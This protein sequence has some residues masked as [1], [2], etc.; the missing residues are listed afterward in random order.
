[1]PKF[2]A[3]N[4]RQVALGRG[5]A[6]SLR[7]EPYRAALKAGKAG[8]IELERGDTPQRVK[9]DLGAAAREAGV[10]IRSTWQDDKQRV[11]LWKKVGE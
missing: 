8:C 5:R 6:G 3:L 4:P 9:I 7:R 10:R 2:Q 1:M 11:L